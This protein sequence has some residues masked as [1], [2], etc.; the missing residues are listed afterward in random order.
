MLWLA[1]KVFGENN[2]KYLTF[3]LSNCSDY[4]EFESHLYLDML[5]VEIINPN[6]KQMYDERKI[7]IG[8]LPKNL[9][10]IDKYCD[11]LTRKML[12]ST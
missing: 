11:R 6:F 5:D 4:Q 1:L 10:L 2:N 8:Q 7:L 3:V 9:S 12:Y